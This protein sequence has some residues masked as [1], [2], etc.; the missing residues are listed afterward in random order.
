MCYDA[1]GLL[2][3]APMPRQR[4]ALAWIFFPQG[5]AG[6]VGCTPR[7]HEFIHVVAIIYL[8]D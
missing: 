8:Y 6:D 1:I 2:R 5:S 7:C 3:S 4:R